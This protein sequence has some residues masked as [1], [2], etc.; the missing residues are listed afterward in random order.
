MAGGAFLACDGRLWLVSDAA[1]AAYDPASGQ[2]SK[3]A[4]NSSIDGGSPAVCSAGRILVFTAAQTLIYNPAG[5]LWAAAAGMPRPRSATVAT[6]A[7]DGRVWVLGGRDASDRPTPYVDV[8]SPVTRTWSARRALLRRP[9]PLAAVRGIAGRVIALG[10]LVPDGLGWIPG[11]IVERSPL[12]LS[13]DQQAPELGLATP[14]LDAGIVTFGDPD[15]VRGRLLVSAPDPSGLCLVEWTRSEDD[16][17]AEAASGPGQFWTIGTRYSYSVR[18]S[19]CAG[20]RS[21]WQAGPAFTASLHQES[22]AAYTGS[23]MSAS[24]G[25]VGSFRSSGEAGA[26]ASFTYT[27]MAV[28]WLGTVSGDGLHGAASVALD[29]RPPLVIDTADPTLS[30]TYGALNWSAASPLD[31]PHTVKITD[32]GTAGRPAVDV[33]G[34]VVLS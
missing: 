27:G 21:D 25:D 13:H 15:S 26:T 23:W 30:G 22:E 34:F 7:T 2:W 18:L 9:A 31:G 28:A 10:G 29:E 5:N 8:F 17:P 19:D 3:H 14:A 33:A 4:V 11:T 16:G 12:G 1:T 32:Q 20:N 6:R 24:S